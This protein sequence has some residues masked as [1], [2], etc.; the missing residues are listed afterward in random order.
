MAKNTY[1]SIITLNV[2]GLNVPI[3][4]HKGAD[5]MKKQVPTICCLHKTHIKA[6]DTYK[7]KVRGMERDISCERKKQDSRS[8]STHIRQNR[9]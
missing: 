1:L 2:N 7:L 5:C 6:K 9:L 4:S 3:K 8:C